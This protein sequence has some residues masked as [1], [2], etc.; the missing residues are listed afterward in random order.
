MLKIY[1][2]EGCPFAHRSRALLNHLGVP[3]ELHEID[4]A[5]RDSEFLKLTPTG[6]VP[7]L[8]N[9]DFVLYES[10]IINTYLAEVHGWERALANNP[11]LR[12]RQRLAMKQW[13]T[14]VL[15]AFYDSL[16]NPASLDTARSAAVSKELDQLAATVEEM[17]TEVES[18]LAFHVATHWARMGWLRSY[19]GVVELSRN[20][21]RCGSGSIGPR[22][23]R[24]CR[25]RCQTATQPFVATRSATS[26]GSQHDVRA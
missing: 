18:L 9:G 23:S 19:T 11:R 17:G 25:K 12:A 13:D 2:A 8:A 15:P 7:L 4:L 22:R 20:D 14:T 6:R 3:F 1:S 24:R 26:V 16:R 21:R 5:N 10:Q